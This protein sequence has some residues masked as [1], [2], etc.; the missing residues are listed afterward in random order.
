ML[1]Y[2]IVRSVLAVRP[3]NVLA[4]LDNDVGINL[5]LLVPKTFQNVLGAGH[6]AGLC[7]K[8]RSRNVG[9]H[10]IATAQLRVPHVA[11]LVPRVVRRRGLRV[12]NV[13][14]VAVELTVLESLGNVLLDTNGTTSRIHNP[15]ARL[16]LADKLL[17]E[18]THGASVE[19]RIDGDYI[20]ARHKVLEVLD[21]LATNLLLGSIIKLVVVIV[22]QLLAVEGLEALQDTTANAANTKRTDHLV[23]DIVRVHG[24]LSDIP[25]AIHVLVVRRHKVADKDQDCHDSVLSDRSHIRA[26]HLVHTNFARVGRI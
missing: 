8:R 21:T 24:N 1:L 20:T 11:H 2:L 15:R 17:I 18:E 9:R 25:C 7:I 16:H 6:V 5:G 13:T 22:Q 4:V 23:L 3:R 10:R 14:T 19:R 26:G 12:G